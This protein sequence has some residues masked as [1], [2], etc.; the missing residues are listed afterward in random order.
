MRPFTE[1]ESVP[2]VKSNEPADKSATSGLEVKLWQ[3][4][5]ALA[6]LEGQCPAADDWHT[7]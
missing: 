7:G 5:D 3:T 1:R 6:R 2:N 4:A